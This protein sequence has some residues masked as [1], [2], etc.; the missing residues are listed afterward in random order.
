[1]SPGDVSYYIVHSFSLKYI[2]TLLLPFKSDNV[3]LCYSHEVSSFDPFLIFDF[4]FEKCK[5]KGTYYQWNN[6]IKKNI[7]FIRDGSYD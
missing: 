6:S 2:F 4:H 1:M 5:L 3:V 7:D